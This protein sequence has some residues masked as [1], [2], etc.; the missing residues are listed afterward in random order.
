MGKD[1]AGALFDAELR[2]FASAMAAE[3]MERRTADYLSKALQGLPIE[4]QLEI[5]RVALNLDV[6]PDEPQWVLLLAAGHVARFTDGLAATL[7]ASADQA[8]RRLDAGVS[9][10]VGTLSEMDEKFAGLVEHSVSAMER[11]SKIHEI[12]EASGQRYEETA[13]RHAENLQAVVGTLIVQKLGDEYSKAITKAVADYDRRTESFMSKSEDDRVKNVVKL[14][15]AV[16][17]TVKNIPAAVSKGVVDGARKF[18]AERTK[19]NPRFRALALAASVAFAL[20]IAVAGSLGYWAGMTAGDA[21][22]RLDFQ[23][24]KSAPISAT[25]R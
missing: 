6:R 19:E 22:A 25:R 17:E 7:S 16:D 21:Q 14:T 3:G 8:S 5:G 23:S 4:R 18:E 9:L 20:S 13:R 24:G 11:V 10:R 15:A 12:F 1:D 2:D